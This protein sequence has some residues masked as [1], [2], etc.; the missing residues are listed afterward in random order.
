[1]LS[2]PHLGG[3]EIDA[4]EKVVE[5]NWIAPVGPWI[6]QF[7]YGL[8]RQLTEESDHAVVAL[9][10]GT[11]ALHLG[12]IL[13]GVRPGDVVLC[14]SFTFSASANPIA[15][16]GAEPVFIDSEPGTWNMDPD[17]LEEAL[18][19]LQREGKRVGAII[20]VHLYGMPAQMDRIMALAQ[21]YGVPVL[22]DAA[23][24]LGSTLHGQACGT[25]GNLGVF[26]FNGNKIITTGGGGALLG[27]DKGLIDR[28]RYLATQSRDATPEYNHREI[29][30]NYA[31]SNVLAAIGC[32]QLEVLPERIQARRENFRIYRE[33]LGGI[34][35][36]DFLE[37]PVGYFSNR[38]LTTITVDPART[39][40][41]RE[42]LRLALEAHNIE[43]R[44]LWKPMHQQPIFATCRHFGR[45]VS[46]AL[47]ADG[48][49]L[50]SGS[51]L[52]VS[53]LHRVVDLITQHVKAAV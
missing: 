6:Q 49:C 18:K 35:G 12:L 13:L 9:N 15:Y 52:N 43:S 29:G 44:P 32:A 14:Q 10:S 39:G 3:L 23:E 40:T 22:E 48:L 47:F 37:E 17:L 5:S 34:D 20:P 51:N 21:R 38:W 27:K 2:S 36:V 1:M 19:T 4:L 7:E 30:Y 50:P 11:S 45:G 33:L 42:A 8:A 31:L 24:A 16:V 53:D 41:T 46:D 25:F 28:A 26:S